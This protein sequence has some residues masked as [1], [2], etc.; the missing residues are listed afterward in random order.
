MRFDVT[1]FLT[2]ETA[3]LKER[4]QKLSITPGLALLWVG[5]DPQTALFIRAK[6]KM[7]QELGCNFFLHHFDT[8]HTK[9][10]LAVVKGLNT[11][12]DVQGIVV[13][14]PLPKDIDTPAIIAAIAPAKDVDGLGKDSRFFPPTPKGILTLLEQAKIDPAK[15]KTVLLGQGRLVGAPLAEYFQKKA[16]PL[17]VIDA[18][19]E[20]QA[21]LIKQHT[22]LIAATGVEHLVTP[23]MVHPDMTVID[24]SGIDVDSKTI[25]PLV[26]MITP[27]RGAIGPLTVFYL[28]SNLVAAS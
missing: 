21:N 19:A 15:E 1:D 18:Q 9:Q 4:R 17:T 27:K 26:K 8:A 11:R 2:A 14:L 12:P 20:K 13:Q 10:I 5:N 3:A 7:A 22:L 25:E 23:P 16:W 24:A 6:Q 28:F